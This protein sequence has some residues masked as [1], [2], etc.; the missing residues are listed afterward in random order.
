MNTPSFLTHPSTRSA[1]GN[2]SQSLRRSIA[3]L[4]ATAQFLPFVANSSSSGTT[5]TLFPNLSP[6]RVDFVSPAYESPNHAAY[7]QNVMNALKNG[8]PSVGDQ[9]LDPAAFNPLGSPIVNSSGTVSLGLFDMV[10]FPA[11]TWRGTVPTSG[12]FAEERGTWFRPSARVVSD[13]PFT[14][15]EV[16]V[17]IADDTFQFNA[18]LAD[19]SP[20]A[21]DFEGLWWG[22]DQMK[23]TP[24][25]VMYGLGELA[26]AGLEINELYWTGPGLLYSF[27]GPPLPT[28]QDY[29]AD[30]RGYLESSYPDGYSFN[31]SVSLRDTISDVTAQVVVPEASSNGATALL[32]TGLGVSIV[33]RRRARLCT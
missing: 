5:I 31:A 20:Q 4:A 3:I 28:P 18:T 23:G 16:I 7:V 6:T 25:D 30:F 24:D 13:H 9:T 22:T 12:P 17:G 21:L 2:S 29:L 32:L 26:P 8:L 14:T 1:A 19:T 15:A 11:N 27:F 33:H 10:A